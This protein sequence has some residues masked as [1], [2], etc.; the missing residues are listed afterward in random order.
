LASG[1]KTLTPQGPNVCLRGAP[2]SGSRFHFGN[3]TGEP[4]KIIA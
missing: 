2:V 1:R 3:G 4:P